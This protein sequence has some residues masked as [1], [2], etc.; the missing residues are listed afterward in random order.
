M[1]GND[2]G[3]MK[4]LAAVTYKHKKNEKGSVCVC[5]YTSLLKSTALL[6]APCQQCSFRLMPAALC[7]SRK[8]FT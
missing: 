4:R 2:N 5:V 3:G 6:L 8:D 1:T 7:C